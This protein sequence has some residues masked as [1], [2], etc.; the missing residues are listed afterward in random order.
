MRDK[1][2]FKLGFLR[3]AAELG[4]LP[5]DFEKASAWGP[6]LESLKTLSA[7]GLGAAFLAGGGLGAMGRRAAEADK[8][9][10]DEIKTQYVIDQYRR[11][12]AK[13]RERTRR[14]QAELQAGKKI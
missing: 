10:L 5:S 9:E 11:E 12:A 6:V 1:Q 13:I 14:R 4:L 3:R 2:R 8:E 7:L